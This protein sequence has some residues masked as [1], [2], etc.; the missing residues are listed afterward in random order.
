MWGLEVDHV[1]R[2]AGLEK[3]DKPKFC[4]RKLRGSSPPSHILPPQKRVLELH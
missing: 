4:V 3:S 2:L 1:P